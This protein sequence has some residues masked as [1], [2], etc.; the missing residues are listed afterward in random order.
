[1]GC[2]GKKL[3]DLGSRQR[4]G[5]FKELKSRAEVALWFVKSYG[6]EFTCLKGVETKHGNLYTVVLN[7]KPP[8]TPNTDM[9]EMRNWNK[10][11]TYWIS[12]VPVIS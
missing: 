3:G 7:N 10:F 8:A 2:A 1:M 9:E 12:S 6:L 11:S 5:K 4:Y